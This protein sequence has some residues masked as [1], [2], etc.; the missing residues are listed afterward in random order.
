MQQLG[1]AAR[2]AGVFALVVLASTPSWGEQHS[3]FDAE[4]TRAIERITREYILKNPEILIE[5]GKIL[6]ARRKVAEQERKRTALAANRDDLENDPGSPVG[7]HPEGSVTIVEFFDY[8]CPYCKAVAPRLAR[9]LEQDRD[10]RFVYKEW[11][12]LG[13][14]SEYAANV[15][16]AAWKQDQSKYEAFHTALMTVKGQLT[17]DTVLQTARE[18]GLDVD[19]LRSDMRSPEIVAIIDR[20]MALARSLGITGTPTF[21]IGDTLVPGA[22]S[23]AQLKA[24]VEQARQGG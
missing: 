20:N 17:E 8:R 1:L 19:R 15:A 23:L 9:L 13:P 14:A 4:Q 10:I 2:A 5:A 18:L 6:E 7:G 11:P 22:A 3:V 16:L 12:I 21:V 24:L